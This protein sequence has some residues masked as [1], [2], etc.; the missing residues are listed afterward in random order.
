MPA[1]GGIWAVATKEMDGKMPRNNKQ[2]SH[3]SLFSEYG[4]PS[5]NN[6]QDEKRLMTQKL[7]SAGPWILLQKIIP[8]NCSA[9]SRIKL[10]CAGTTGKTA[11]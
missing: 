11:F 6:L 3:Q 5:E 4:R 8:N 2:N 10:Q 9:G 7:Y 1:P